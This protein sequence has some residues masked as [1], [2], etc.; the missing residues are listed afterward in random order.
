M[1]LTVLGEITAVESKAAPEGA[2]APPPPPPQER[3]TVTITITKPEQTDPLPPIVA[4]GTLT[5]D[6]LA[7]ALGGLGKGPCRVLLAEA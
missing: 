4:E 1:M 3:V 2:P 6:I 7:S 5:V